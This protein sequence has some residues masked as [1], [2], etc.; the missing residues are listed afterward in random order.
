AE[1]PALKLG[2]QIKACG[3]HLVPLAGFGRIVLPDRRMQADLDR[4][5]HQRVIGRVEFDEVDAFSL[6]IVRAQLGRL[7]I[8]KSRQILR[9]G[10]ANVAAEL[11]EIL[12]DRIGKFV[13]ELHEQGISAPRAG[14]SK[15]QALV[16]DLVR[17]SKTPFSAESG[18][19][20]VTGKARRFARK[21]PRNS[22]WLLAGN[23]TLPY[24][25]ALT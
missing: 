16:R 21:I 23:R 17:Q 13:G 14:A 6:P 19:Q 9:F 10:R 8:R 3:A 12:A 25:T 5:A 11:V 15:W 22:R 20:T 2:G 7:A 4:A 1:M 18:S 24:S